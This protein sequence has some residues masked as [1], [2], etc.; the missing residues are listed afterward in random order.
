MKIMKK[1][2]ILLP[3]V[4]SFF[5]LTSNPALAKGWYVNAPVWCKA[6][7]EASVPGNTV[8]VNAG[9]IKQCAANTGLLNNPPAQAQ[10]KAVTKGI[11]GGTINVLGKNGG[12][13][14]SDNPFVNPRSPVPGLDG[15][16]DIDVDV[17]RN[18]NLLTLSGNTQYNA[19]GFLELSVL[20]LSGLSPEEQQNLSSNIFL[21]FGSVEKALEEGFISSNQVLFKKRET[22]FLHSSFSFTVDVTSLADNDIV[23]T[24]LA[25]AISAVV[26]EPTSTLGILALGT[27]GAASTL[28]R[29]L[30][31]SKSSEKETTKVS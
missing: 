24:S 5:G 12:K 29:Q 19:N 26:P 6:G 16:A 22:E 25:H 14:D 20:N 18:S 1:Q 2:A 11:W 3:F 30:K 9:V 4:V 7:A 13:A 17:N 28:K 23:V 8:V 21:D 27:L 15:V 10:A 31:S